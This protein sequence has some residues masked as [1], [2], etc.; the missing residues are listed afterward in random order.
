MLDVAVE[1]GL[2]GERSELFPVLD[3]PFFADDD[4]A[5][6]VFPDEVAG[7]DLLEE[8]DGAERAV[9]HAV[10]DDDV[11]RPRIGLERALHVR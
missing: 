11:P 8:L 4:V 1:L 5:Q 10:F 6:R 7:R 3:E 9:I 2:I